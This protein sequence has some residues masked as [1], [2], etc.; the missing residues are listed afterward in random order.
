[1]I[2]HKMMTKILCTILKKITA[3][4][5]FQ[6]FLHTIFLNKLLTSKHMIF[7]VNLELINFIGTCE[8]FK[9]MHLPKRLVQFQRFEKLT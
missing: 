1:M 2:S 6:R 7:L 5:I 9:T 3:R 4:K 8:F